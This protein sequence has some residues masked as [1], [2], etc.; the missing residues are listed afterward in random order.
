MK[1]WTI[2]VILSVLGVLVGLALFG[3]HVNP[4]VIAV[5]VLVPFY[6]VGSVL[7]ACYILDTQY[8]EFRH[9]SSRA[10]V[11]RS[12]HAKSREDGGFDGNK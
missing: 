12:P 10:S 1:V 7:A 9:R 3:S 4:F 8:W 6:Y 5:T 2:F 11:G